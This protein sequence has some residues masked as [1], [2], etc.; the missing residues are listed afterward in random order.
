MWSWYMAEVCKPIK[1]IK[2]NK[3]DQNAKFDI[4]DI[5]MQSMQLFT[6]LVSKK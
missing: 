3:Y 6:F 5:N 2:L 1:V 4:Y